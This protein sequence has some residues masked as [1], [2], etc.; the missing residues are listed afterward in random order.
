MDFKNK[1]ILLF[2]SIFFISLYLS[3]SST[4]PQLQKAR[5]NCTARDIIE[6][7]RRLYSAGYYKDA[8]KEY[9]YLIARFPEERE[10]CAWAQYE[11][12]YCYY[13]MEDYDR[14]IV[15][16]KRVSMLYPD[17]EAPVILANKMITEAM[18]KKNK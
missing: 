9:K 14:A 3:C 10:L 12:A 16:F 13:V 8:I 11:L 2:S 7:A 15:E 17:Q 18:L 1:H 6:Y 5:E 4:K